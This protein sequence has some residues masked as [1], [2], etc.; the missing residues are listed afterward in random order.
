MMYRQNA[1]F[2][3][4]KKHLCFA[5]HPSHFASSRHHNF[6]DTADTANQDFL[7]E[8]KESGHIQSTIEDLAQKH[9]VFD[10]IPSTFPID[11]LIRRLAAGA[12]FFAGQM[13]ATRKTVYAAWRNHSP[14]I[15]IKQ[16]PHNA[17]IITHF[18]PVSSSLSSDYHTIKLGKTEISIVGNLPNY[19]SKNE[20][21]YA[22]IKA[23][24]MRGIDAVR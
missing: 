10:T 3:P 9:I 22:T 16:V 18:L 2:A 17:R 13:C 15:L 8:H 6:A 23:G 12:W 14:G 20:S 4:V 5:L 11:F 24:G 19:T 1:L 7:C 21:S